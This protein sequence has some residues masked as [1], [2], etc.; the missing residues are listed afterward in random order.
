MSATGLSALVL[1]GGFFFLMFLHIPV[2]FSM[3]HIVRCVP[4][5][6][7]SFRPDW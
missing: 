4:F 1:M 7:V 6:P 5:V 3:S 2:T